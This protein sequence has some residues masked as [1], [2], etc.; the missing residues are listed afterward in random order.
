MSDSPQVYALRSSARIGLI[1]DSHGNVRFLLKAAETLGKQGVTQLIQLGDFGMLFD[2]PHWHPSKI[3]RLGQ[4]ILENGQQLFFLDGNHEN[5]DLI[6]DLP[7][8][9]NGTRPVVPGITYL[10]RGWRRTFYTGRSLAVLGGANSIDY[11]RRTPGLSGWAAESITEV[12]LL[13][14]GNVHADIMIGHDAPLNF[15]TLDEFLATTARFWTA[16]GIRYANAGREMFHRGFLQVEPA[17]YFGGHYHQR[18]DERIRFMN[19]RGGFDTHVV[20]LDSD[21]GHI[22]DTVAI[23]DTDTLAVTYPGWES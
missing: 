10:P 21:M 18:F 20:I 13:N 17:V 22:E 23:L 11:A 5:F 15:P 12:D 4:H 7:T 6:S 9:V 16:D 3:W 2:P 14:L 19:E 8:G 1:G